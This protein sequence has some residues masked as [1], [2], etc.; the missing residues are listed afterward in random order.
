MTIMNVYN[1]AAI[2]IMNMPNGFIDLW[3]LLGSQVDPLG[4]PGNRYR[5]LRSLYEAQ[6]A[7]F[8]CGRL[9]VV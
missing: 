8:G 5:A 7:H 2:R 3:P 4:D 6:F 1:V 9:L